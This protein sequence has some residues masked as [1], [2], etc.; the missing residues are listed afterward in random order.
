MATRRD[1]LLLA[2]HHGTPLAQQAKLL[3]F[4]RRMGK[5]GQG[6]WKG[7]QWQKH[8]GTHQQS[9]SYWEGSWKHRQP[10]QAN[11]FPDY[12]QTHV[13]SW[14][15][16][17]EAQQCEDGDV[18]PDQHGISSYMKELQKALTA[19]RKSEGRLR[20][21]QEG[22]QL[23]E[24]QWLQYQADLKKKFIEQKRAFSRDMESFAQEMTQA[25]AAS[26]AAV[27]RVQDLAS[28]GVGGARPMDMEM[29]ALTPAEDDDWSEFVKGS[30][31]SATGSNAQDDLLAR[32]LQEAHALSTQAV[33]LQQA[34][35]VSPNRAS[36]TTPKRR[37]FQEK[38]LSGTRRLPQQSTSL[39]PNLPPATGTG[40]GPPAQA[41]GVGAAYPKTLLPHAVN[42]GTEASLRATDAGTF[43]F[44][45]VP[46]V[47]YGL[48]TPA[49][50]DPYMQSPTPAASMPTFGKCA[51]PKRSPHGQRP[52]V[53]IKALSKQGP[54][55]PPTHHTNL[56]DVVQAK[57]DQLM[58]QLSSQGEPPPI[59]VPP[60]QG[61]NTKLPPV[62]LEDDDE[63]SQDVL[64][65]DGNQLTTLE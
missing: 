50:R 36:Q 61:D 39:L 64:E 24:R 42:V 6:E 48:A 17:T 10:K 40:Q 21:L 28:G 57:R 2:A 3:T 22:K 52:R 18:D 56:A 31:A 49:E 44:G 26:K 14:G 65:A 23:K 15:H 11:S 32:A 47:Q 54:A 37:T 33:A 9:W 19:C 63:E 30:E 4:C 60:A 53:S 46:Q 41:S 58:A 27:E 59:P 25:M 34:V 38:F 43:Q 35:Q 8:G 20:R 13:E 5:K 7:A 29:P 45:T 16:A 12:G 62:F 51:T 1:C 55:A